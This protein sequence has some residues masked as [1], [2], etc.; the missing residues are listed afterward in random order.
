MWFAYMYQEICEFI[1]LL[2]GNIRFVLK[3][4]RKGYKIRLLFVDYLETGHDPSG[5]SDLS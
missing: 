4:P 3:F 1:K 5:V 2:L